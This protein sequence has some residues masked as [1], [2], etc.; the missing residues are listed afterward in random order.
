MLRGL[1][2]AVAAGRL[3]ATQTARFWFL[4]LLSVRFRGDRMNSTP[5]NIQQKMDPFYFGSVLD[6]IPVSTSC[7]SI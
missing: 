1:F 2:Q 7:V 4:I 6:T 3:H 5:S